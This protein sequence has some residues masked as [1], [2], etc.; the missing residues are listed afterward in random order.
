MEILVIEEIGIE[1]REGETGREA[2]PTPRKDS[3]GESIATCVQVAT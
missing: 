2:D 1:I 3:V